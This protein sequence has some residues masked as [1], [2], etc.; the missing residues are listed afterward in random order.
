[1]INVFEIILKSFKQ[2]KKNFNW[3]SS[4]KGI[5]AQSYAQPIK[6]IAKK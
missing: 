6:F 5:H 3:S 4:I 2:H 1:M